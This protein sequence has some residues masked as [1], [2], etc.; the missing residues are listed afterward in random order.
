MRFCFRQPAIRILLI[1]FTFFVWSG[2]TLA[3]VCGALTNR[4]ATMEKEE[5]EIYAKLIDRA[6]KL[7]NA[8]G[9]LWKI[10]K[11]GLEPSWLFGTMHV[12]D[13]RI[14]TLAEPVEQAFS[15]AR[16]TAFEI[17]MVGGGRQAAR[18]EMDIVL[19]HVILRGSLRRYL[20]RADLETVAYAAQAHNVHPNIIFR[21]KPLFIIFQLGNPT[22]ASRKTGEGY[23]EDVLDLGLAKRAKREGKTVVGL[24]TLQEHYGFLDNDMKMRDQLRLLVLIAQESE[25]VGDDSE[26]YIAAYQR[27]N[28]SPL[29]VSDKMSEFIPESWSAEDRELY[30][31][32]GTELL[33]TKRNHLM[34]SRA[35]PIIEQGAAFVAIGA[36]HL[37][38]DEG[39][40]ELLRAEG[41]TL[42]RAW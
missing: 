29:I 37:S 33:L 6:S 25:V 21:V 13:K 40:V 11:Q 20:K 26:T 42:T 4:L 18:D 3:D 5:P 23:S 10:E 35:V 38:G 1:L 41:Y 30:R 16:H 17:D 27:R 31:R 36:A 24:E 32:Y 8:E 39:M 15:A 19:N 12:T 7:A 28:L 34:T 2:S 9:L 14:T 22:C